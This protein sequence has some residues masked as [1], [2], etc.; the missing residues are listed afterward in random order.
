[1]SAWSKISGRMLHILTMTWPSLK[2]HE[3]VLFSRTKRI[4]DTSH[5]QTSKLNLPN[6][7][8]AT[9]N[10]ERT[11]ILYLNSLS[12]TIVNAYNRYLLMA[13]SKI[14]IQIIAYTTE[15]KILLKNTRDV[16]DFFH[17]PK[18]FRDQRF[19]LQ[20]SLIKAFR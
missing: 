15:F 1:M 2:R 9:K 8:L 13:S 18:Q 14:R 20:E 10:I 7:F 6:T 19:K 17:S 5:L 11:E 4:Q 12:L 3:F 16:H